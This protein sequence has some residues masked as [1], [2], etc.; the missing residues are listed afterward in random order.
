MISKFSVKK[1]YTVLVGVVLAILLGV[2][3]FTRMTADLLPDISLPYV[4]VMTTY[5][6]ASPETVEMAVTQPVES[7]MATVS[8]IEGISSVSNENYS[9]VILEF[10]QTADM[11]AVSLEI[12]EN[13]DQ[14]SSYWDDAVGNPIIMKMNPDMLP[15]MIAAVGMEGM[16]HGEI[17]DYVEESIVPELES[18]EGV[19]S[20][21]ATGLLEESVNVII[22][23]E[24]IDEVNRKVFAAIDEKLEESR[25]E[26]EDGKKEIADGK[27]EL[28]DG[29]KDLLKAQREL[30]DGRNELEK[31]KQ[32]LENGKTELQKKQDETNQQLAVQKN[33]LLSAKASLEGMRTD[34]ATA[35]S[36]NEGLRQIDEGI[37][38][39]AAMQASVSGMQASMNSLQGEQQSASASYLATMQ[40]MGKAMAGLAVSSGDAGAAGRLEAARNQINGWKESITGNAVLAQFWGQVSDMAAGQGMTLP[41]MEEL[42]AMDWTDPA[43]AMTV[44]AV[45]ETVS[46]AVPAINGELNKQALELENQRA[47][48]ATQLDYATNGLG[49]Q[50]YVAQINQILAAQKITDLNKAIEDLNNGLIQLEQGQITAAVEFANGKA[51]IALGEYQLEVAESELESGK[52]QIESGLEQMEDARK[53]LDDA[54]EQIA[55]GEEQLEEARQNAY[56]QADMSNVIT[57]DLIRQLLTAQNFSMPAGYVTE[58][59]IDYLVRVGDK[60]GTV[61][62]LQALPL[63]DLHMDG[64]P[65]VT[66]G[67]VADVFY[68]DNSAEIYTNVNGS[69][70]VMLTIQKQT[71]YSTGEVSDLLAE[72]FEELTE[73]HPG[74]SLITLM[75]QG[76]Y[77]DLVMDSIFNNIIFGFGLAV[78]IL[79]LFLK[80]LRP[81]AIVAVSV[82]ISLV[83]AVVCMYFSG[84]TLN[85]ISLSGLALGIGMLVD[86]SIVVIENIYRLRSLGRD[87][88]EA[89]MEG[90]KEVA[91]AIVASTLTTVCVFLPIVFTEGITRQLFVDM[92]LTIAYS[93]LA[94]LIIALTVVPAMA[95]KI[96]VKAKEQKEGGVFRAIVN[97]Y[98]KVLRIALKGKAVV[99]IA[100]LLLLAASIALAYTNGTAFMSD[101]DSTQLTVSVQL[102]DDATLAETGEITDRVVDAILSLEDVENVGAMT[103][104]STLSMLGGGGGSTNATSIYVVT[105][106]DKKRSNEEIADLILEKTADLDAEVT[107]DTSSMDMSALGGSGISIQV[108]GRDLDELQRIAGEVAAIVESVEGTAQVSDGLG[109]TEEELR[110]IIDRDQA[111]HYGL[112]VAQV[113]TQIYGRV[114][115]AGSATTLVAADR[116]YNVYVMSGNDIELT[117]ELV[118]D[119]GITGTDENGESVEVPLREI[120]SFETTAAL[121]SINRQD[122]SRYVTVSA[123]I[124]E[125]YNVGLVS[126]AVERKLAGYELPAGYRLVFSGE[127]EMINDAMSQVLLMLALAVAFMYLIMVAQFQSLKS[128]F[129]IMFTIPLAFTGGF[130][131][132][133]ISGSEISVIAMIGFVMLAGIIVNNGIVLIDYINQLRER[134]MEK[135]EAILE[136]GRTRL[137]PV[138]MTALTTI[139]ALSTMVFSNDMGS[140]M[141]KPM[142]VVTIGGLVYGTLLTLIVIPCI[143]DLFERKEKGEKRRRKVSGIRT[144]LSEEE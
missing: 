55:D 16:D 119:L 63:L 74:L 78:L 87:V 19:A 58:E 50:K 64:V 46:A 109:E 4:I 35:A 47:A 131:G 1:P 75:D 9:M 68:T 22:R 27:Q 17:S 135:K 67:D 13:L 132:L 53:Q 34:L 29:K 117:R 60:P 97:V 108:R 93:L 113:Y 94:S 71:G 48:L 2:V 61:E 8:N 79:I 5:P 134:N 98:E 42:K 36:L 103:S 11:N 65:V 37:G 40:E 107:A 77:I 140:E 66:L 18:I 120:A 54:E 106:E 92:G 95:S 12:R 91:G 32:E 118:K 137:R 126:G 114:T 24:K 89:A 130:L 43:N 101:M 110:I 62:E 122:Q 83:T 76:I 25:Q 141:A 144:G 26:L 128:P 31:G 99:L 3:S 57:V 84:V 39:V 69:A 28:E 52:A 44:V 56:E 123:G 133:F 10:S 73:E 104:T 7:S 138:L 124:A 51:Q 81:T 80:D 90:A 30:A 115:E 45:L 23:Q 49:Y 85:I 136:A 100:V 21:S 20:V 127:N 82:P 59:G 41:S 121:T 86:N 129:I 116:D 102:A 6:G 112:T 88:R 105:R 38:T 125:G 143:Y 96:L 33:A 72:R 70:G 15:I 142:A 139:L 111:V 14:I